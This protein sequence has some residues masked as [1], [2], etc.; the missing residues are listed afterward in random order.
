VVALAWA[1]R[2]A[3]RGPVDDGTDRL[4]EVTDG[5]VVQQ[6]HEDA[7]DVATLGR[8]LYVVEDVLEVSAAERGQPEPGAR[9]A[10]TDSVNVR[11][12]R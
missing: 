9:A 5:G 2:R 8:V 1:G 3:P 10:D 6:P 11:A 7:L 4:Q 12:L